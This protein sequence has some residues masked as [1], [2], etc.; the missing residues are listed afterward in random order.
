MTAL[1]NYQP[2]VPLSP[3]FPAAW[4]REIAEAAYEHAATAFPAEAAGYVEGGVYFP[5]DNQSSTPSDDVRISDTDLLRVAG[6]DLFFHSHPNANGCPS[7]TDMVYQQ[8]LGIPFV[9]MTLPHYDIFAFGDMLKRAPLIGRGFRHGVHDCYAL[10]R[11]WYLEKGITKLWDQPR[12]W[13]WWSNKQNLYVENF[14]AAG[15]DKIDRDAAT[16]QGDLLLFNFNYGV[17][18]H[19][20]LVID[21]GLLMHHASGTKAVDPTRLSTLVPRQ[22]MVRHASMALRH[23]DL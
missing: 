13:E 2:V 12:G 1:P 15:F 7:E 18:M 8:Q 6:A 11:D 21:G 22:R 23:R 4:T 17:P 9:V 20:A 5:L 10:V 16:R 19:A 14:A 3:A